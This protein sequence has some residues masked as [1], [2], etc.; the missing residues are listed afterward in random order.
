MDTDKLHRLKIIVTGTGRCGTKFA[1]KLLTSAGLT[2]G[3]ERF[4]DYHGL[5]WAREQLAHFWYGT[6]GESSWCAVPFLDDETL[7]DA[8]LVHLIRHPQDYIGSLLKIWP[9]DRAHT[10]YTAYA[11]NQ[12]PELKEWD[13][14]RVT[15]AALKW[16][17][18]NQMVDA[19]RQ[20]RE[21]VQ[22]QIERE[23]AD[24]IYSLVAHGIIESPTDELFDNRKANTQIQGPP[25]PFELSDIAP[26]V[27]DEMLEL[28]S[29]YGYE[30]KDRPLVIQVKSQPVIKAIITTIDN[31]P[32][33][34]EQLAVL[35]DEPIDRIIFV[36]NGSQDGAGEWLDT[37][38]G[39]AVIHRENLGAGPGRNAGLDLAGQFDY[40]LMLDGGIRPLRGGTRQFLRYLERH[41][42]ADVIGVEIPDFE[43]DYDKAWWRWPEKMTIE[44]HAYPNNRLAHTAYAL[45]RYK[46]WDGLRWC[47]EGPFGEPGWGA[48]DDEMAYQWNNAGIIVHVVTCRCKHGDS[49]SG[50]HPYRRA[51]GSF[52]RLEKETGVWPTDF[53][54]VYE[55][56]VV[57]LEQN[58]PQYEPGLQW[59]EPYL[60]VVVRGDSVQQAAPII[61]RAHDKL[62]ERVFKR[63]F[64]HTPNPYSIVL[65]L[66]GDEQL[67]RWADLHRLH[68]H[69]GTRARNNGYSLDRTADNDQWWT[70]NFRVW[71]GDDWREAMRPNAHY[72]T[73]VEDK[74]DLERVLYTYNKLHPRTPVKRP[75]DVIR[76][77]IR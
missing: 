66:Q 69:Y 48:D 16:V 27:R 28:A 74:G 65:W 11:Q 30:W 58:W 70:G 55:K 53:G 17:R 18:F 57:W 12:A 39:I 6:Y 71:T 31:L 22:F 24:L 5:E 40:A 46:A 41:T 7:R 44:G 67:E 13:D 62:R 36:D 29:S 8:F 54:S 1:S 50:V 21:S 38:P 23:P 20:G 72:Y 47:E 4:F 26:S 32:N 43:T 52:R 10:V 60:T 63:P 45:T 2:C 73:L 75:P 19:A 9:P 68:R 61:K 35:R 76:E 59:G 3:H 64:H 77:E 15:W 34:K 42:E 33:N 49:C 14:E 25:F 56:R 37:Q 51:S